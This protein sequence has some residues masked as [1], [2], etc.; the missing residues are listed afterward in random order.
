MRLHGT[1]WLFA[2]KKYMMQAIAKLVEWNAGEMGAALGKE[3]WRGLSH[4]HK[5]ILHSTQRA[6]WESGTERGITSLGI[7]RRCLTAF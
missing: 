4:T 6:G 3:K 5:L 7:I 2:A 1:C